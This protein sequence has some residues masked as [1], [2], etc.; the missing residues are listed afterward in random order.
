MFGSDQESCT[1]REVLEHEQ[2]FKR[3]KGL[4]RIWRTC[5]SQ[6]VFLGTQFSSWRYP[7]HHL[8]SQHVDQGDG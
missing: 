6:T 2:G 1:I 8:E 3:L 5:G 7:W 4:K